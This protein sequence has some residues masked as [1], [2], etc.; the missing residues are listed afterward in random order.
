MSI[1]TEQAWNAEYTM[2]HESLVIVDQVYFN[3]CYHSSIASHEDVIS[4][5]GFQQTK[6]DHECMVETDHGNMFAKKDN[7]RDNFSNINEFHDKCGF[8]LY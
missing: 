5:A 3:I 6:E 4:I 1:E 2:S 7:L 8:L